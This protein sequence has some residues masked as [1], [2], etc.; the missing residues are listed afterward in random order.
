[1]AGYRLATMPLT[2]TVE[3]RSMRYPIFLGKKE[4]RPRMKSTCLIEE[5]AFMPRVVSVDYREFGMN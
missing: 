5:G 2:S 4:R 3:C 1:M